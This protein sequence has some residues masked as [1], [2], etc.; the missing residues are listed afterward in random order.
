VTRWGGSWTKAEPILR[1]LLQNDAADGFMHLSALMGKMRDTR[2]RW[3]WSNGWQP[4]IRRCRKRALRWHRPLPMPGDSMRD[5]G[6]AAGRQPAPWLGVCGTD[7]RADP[8]EDSRAAPWPSCG[9][10][11]PFI[12]THDEVR[13]AY[14]R[15]L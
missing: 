14:A 6:P 13:L 9:I 4:I 7:A 8:R 3:N 5:R 2:P 12:R 11:W 15:N 10:F 1:A